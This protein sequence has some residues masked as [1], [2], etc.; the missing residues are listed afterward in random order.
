[1]EPF[2]SKSG[3]IPFPRTKQEWEESGLS[4]QQAEHKLRC[5]VFGHD[6]TT[7]RSGNP[8]EKGKGSAAQQTAQSKMAYE[9][10]H[11]SKRP[12]VGYSGGEQFNPKAG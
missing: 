5:D 6:Y 11:P 7:D 9:R 2:R 10:A 12:S 3:R 8:V 4:P 1:M